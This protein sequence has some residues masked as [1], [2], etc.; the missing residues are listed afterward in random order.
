MCGAMPGSSGWPNLGE[1]YD[2]QASQ[3]KQGKNF[4]QKL[5]ILGVPKGLFM[6]AQWIYC[7][8]LVPDKPVWLKM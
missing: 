3:A 5:D 4:H 7:P 6:L 8:Q 1:S 2:F